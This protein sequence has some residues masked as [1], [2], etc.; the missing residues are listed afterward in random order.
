MKNSIIVYY[1]HISKCVPFYILFLIA[2]MFE[3]NTAKS[4]S[5]NM[6]K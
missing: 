3:K 5:S 1:Y 4:F 2:H 6:I